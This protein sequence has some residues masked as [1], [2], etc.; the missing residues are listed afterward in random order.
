MLSLLLLAACGGTAADGSTTARA[1]HPIEPTV[2]DSA[3]VTIYELPADALE[4]APLVTM[5]S[6]PLAVIGDATLENDVT[7]I[8]A[9]VLLSDGRLAGYDGGLHAIRIFTP[10]GRPERTIGRAGEGPG[11]FRFV[12]ALVAVPGDTL[13][14]TDRSTSRITVVAPDSG[15]IRMQR[16]SL[17]VDG[18][19]YGVGGR[20]TDGSWLFIPIGFIIS[21]N[22]APTTGEPPP[23][24]PFGQLAFEGDPTGFDTL[25]AVARPATIS[26]PTKF[27]GKESEGAGW[28]LF[29]AP[30]SVRPWQ[31][32]AAVSSVTHWEVRLVGADG[33][34]VS[35]YRRPGARRPT[36]PAMRDSVVAAGI[37]RAKE[38]GN[39]NQSPD[40][41]EFSYRNQPMADSLP[42][43]SIIQPSS[44]QL[45][46]VADPNVPGDP[47]V[48]Y[49][50][51]APD[52]SMVGRLFLPSDIRVT[53]FGDD[54]VV[55][56]TQDD[57]GIVRFE[58]HKLR[59]PS[60]TP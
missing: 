56:R 44:G 55:L 1:S 58:V 12:G 2:R 37:R 13:V 19:S 14:A 50:A 33:R 53:A 32:G 41:V 7:R 5:D 31:G 25:G 24:V 42:A 57:D 17:R 6:T 46:W 8:F 45:L 28:R 48:G 11:E 54:R 16:A 23:P 40:D 22:G 52:G 59:M 38:S 21:G 10:D 18:N 27:G 15:M 34:L 4:R 43:I 29:D 47:T 20:L 49:S 51:L 36:T 9:V 26:W 60:T 30:E 3:G 35:L 39:E